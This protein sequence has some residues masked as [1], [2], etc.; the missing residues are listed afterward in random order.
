MNCVSEIYHRINIY[1]ACARLCNL[2]ATPPWRMTLSTRR[3]EIT[4]LCGGIIVIPQVNFKHY[5]KT[6]TGSSSAL[7][8]ILRNLC[9]P[10]SRRDILT[11]KT[12]ASHSRTR[13]WPPSLRLEACFYNSKINYLDVWL[14]RR[15]R[16]LDFAFSPDSEILNHTWLVSSS[17][18]VA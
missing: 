2:L 15:I 18:W 1:Q 7:E 11:P 6:N 5:I 16:L 14:S 3:I 10:L 12:I 13:S 17:L 4:K 8:E 9:N